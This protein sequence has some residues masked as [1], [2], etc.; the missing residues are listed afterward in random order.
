MK[1]KYTTYRGPSMYPT[2]CNGDG[3]EVAPYDVR[4]VRV[5]DVVV[6]PH[7]HRAGDVVHR[8]VAVMPEGVKTRGDN[9]N[10]VDPYVTPYEALQGRV[11]IRRRGDRSRRVWGGKAG[12]LLHRACLLRRLLHEYALR[13]LRPVYHAVAN[14]GRFYG[15]RVPLLKSRT[16]VFHR[17]DGTEIQILVGK[18]IIARRAPGDDT[19]IIAFP[20]RLFIDPRRLPK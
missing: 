17:E 13:F 8:V 2:L 1:T 18:R 6:F 20:F 14:T 10:H 3:L 7:P 4:S 11:V 9:N 5:G 16:V 12:R 15:W 19:W